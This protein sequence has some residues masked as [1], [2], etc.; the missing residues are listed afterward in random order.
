MINKYP[1][2]LSQDV[3]RNLNAVVREIDNTDQLMNDYLYNSEI[4]FKFRDSGEYNDLIMRSI[5]EVL[6]KIEKRVRSKSIYE[7]FEEKMGKVFESV[8]DEDWM[9]ESDE[10][11]EID[12]YDSCQRLNTP[13][14]M[15]PLVAKNSAMEQQMKK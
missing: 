3:N 14:L 12:E 11:S 6:R 9:K 1:T 10:K 4:V 2:T 8:F 5:N 13:P 7:K 15:Q